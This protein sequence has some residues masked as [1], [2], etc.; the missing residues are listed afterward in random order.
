MDNAEI[1]Y[2]ILILLFL[3]VIVFAILCFALKKRLLFRE[4]YSIYRTGSKNPK[5]N[6][7]HQL[8]VFFSSFILTGRF[9]RSLT[10][11]YEVLYPKEGREIEKKAIKLAI[12]I[13]VS[14]AVILAAFLSLDKSWYYV[15]LTVFYLYV[16]GNGLILFEEQKEKR[17]LLI[18]FDSFLSEVRQ[19]YQMHGMIDEA[20]YEAM[21]LCKNPVKLHA[22]CIYDILNS[23]E[24]EKKEDYN[25]YIP[26]RFLKTFLNLCLIIQKY[27]DAE[28][29]GQSLFLINIRYL[30]QE[31]HMEVLKKDKIRHLFSGLTLVAVFPVMFLQIIKNWAVSGLSQLDNFYSGTPGVLLTF[32]IFLLTF[33]S[34]Q[35]LVALREERKRRLKDN[36]ILRNL[37][38]KRIISNLLD[39]ILNKDYGRAKKKE[40]FLRLTGENLTVRQFTLKSLIYGISGFFICIFLIFFLHGA[41]KELR[42]KAGDLPYTT[43][44]LSEKKAQDLSE[45]IISYTRKFLKGKATLEAIEKT[46]KEEGKIKEKYLQKIAAEDIYSRI[47]SIRGEYFKWYELIA[48]LM[49]STGFYYIPYA[50]LSLLKKGRQQEMEDEIFSFQSVILIL[51]HIERAD[52]AVVLEWME[53][54]SYI[55]KDS[56]RTCNRNLSEGEWEAL[57][58]LKEKEPFKPFYKL[59]EELQNSDKIGLRRA[60]DDVEQERANYLEKRALD[61]EISIQEKAI[62][63]KAIAF[64]PFALTVGFYIILPFVLEGLDM[65]KVYIDQINGVGR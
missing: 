55:F 46:I 37:C 24:E 61:N 63:G 41:N 35:L 10:E 11:R 18:Q 26:D 13:W 30:R 49:V 15:L 58:E 51:M 56:L 60:F 7:W 4:T 6:C 8:Y 33:F 14:G 36:A 31:I 64:V 3:F 21:Q 52:I 45:V 12:T 59:I 65:Y 48:A 39:A 47:K 62:L 2:L 42:L 22:Q 16:L 43:S 20:I 34:Y 54:F 38:S 19:Y 25:S 50:V 5:G 1:I 53:E 57:E 40:E 23:T 32:C 29:K 27:G 9:L 17:K 28:V 44:A